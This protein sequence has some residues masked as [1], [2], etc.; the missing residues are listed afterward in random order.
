MLHY[1]HH[2]QQQQQHHYHPRFE[3]SRGH[4]IQAVVTEIIRGFPQVLQ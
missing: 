4:R 1:Y 3:E 2:Q